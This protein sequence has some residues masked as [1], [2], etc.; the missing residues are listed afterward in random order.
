MK[1]KVAVFSPE[2]AKKILDK[3]GITDGFERQ[4]PI[5]PKKL[6]RD[7][8]FHD[9]NAQIYKSVCDEH[10]PP[11][12]CLRVVGSEYSEEMNTDVVL[13]DK[14]NGLPAAFVFNGMYGV[15]KD[16]IANCYT[17]EVRCILSSSH[18]L[19]EAGEIWG[20]KSDFSV[21]PDGVASIKVYGSADGYGVGRTTETGVSDVFVV[22]LVPVG[23][24]DGTS[25]FVTRWRYDIKVVGDDVILEAD[26]DLNASPHIHRRTAKGSYE[27]ASH[28]LACYL[29]GELSVV[30]T[31]EV[32]RVGTC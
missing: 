17:G 16:Q 1:K 20:A 27:K 18:E 21:E 2:L 5:D 3:L 22:E 10:I 13:C 14:P 29:N 7:N 28:G 23:G 8:E 26:A 11:Y 12:A 4:T 15:D 32:P 6:I 30:T 31:N 19:D 9:K 25:E 24:E